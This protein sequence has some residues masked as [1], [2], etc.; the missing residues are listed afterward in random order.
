MKNYLFPFKYKKLGML[1][2]LLSFTSLI[3]AIVFDWSPEALNVTV[4]LPFNDGFLKDMVSGPYE[5]NNILDEILTVI[6]ITT[7]M[8]WCF[9]KEKIEDELIGLIRKDA[10]I[11][12]MYFNYGLFIMATLF[13]YGFSFFNVL[14]INVFT[15]ILVFII[16]F[17]WK[18]YQLKAASHEE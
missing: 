8:L 16:R 12:A 11:W 4:F 14:M 3:A 6:A 2:F 5:K 10:L 18:K 15:P 13:I 9:S 17:E 1:L 7:G